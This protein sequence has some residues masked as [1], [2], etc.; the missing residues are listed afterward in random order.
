MSN[1]PKASARSRDA[2]STK[3]AA[4][5]PL[6][7]VIPALAK[8]VVSVPD[9][10]DETNQKLKTSA[11]VRET[12][13]TTVGAREPLE[14]VIP[15]TSEPVVIITETITTVADT[16]SVGEELVKPPAA[17]NTTNP[18]PMLGTKTMIK[19]TEDF[20]AFGQANVEA[21]VKS[22]QGR[23]RAGADEAIRDRDEGLFR[24][25][26]LRL[27]GDQL[28]QVGHVVAK[29]LAESNK[30]ID[31][32]IKLTEQTLAPISTRVTGAVET[33]GKAA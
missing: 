1:K 18:N 11:Q 6:A 24:R 12:L 30:L 31:T 23:W 25:V 9:T 27:Q 7:K 8:S 20:V 32:S 2:S 19:N 5:E 10:N 28:S 13:P 33:L 15:I 3:P 29:T 14:K 17:I 22:G 26:R 16:G 4:R 21:F